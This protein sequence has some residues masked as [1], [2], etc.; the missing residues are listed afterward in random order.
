[1]AILAV[2]VDESSVVRKIVR[3]EGNE[4]QVEQAFSCGA[5]GYSCRPFIPRRLQE[6]FVPLAAGKP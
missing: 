2:I 3:T 5:R 4:S 6:Q 1:M